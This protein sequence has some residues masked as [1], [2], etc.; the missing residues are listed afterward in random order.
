V[1]DRLA[2]NVVP[3]VENRTVVIAGSKSEYRSAPVTVYPCG[4]LSKFRTRKLRVAVQVSGVGANPNDRLPG[5][6]TDRARA[7]WNA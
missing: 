2:P 5:Q 4:R 6:A 3:F 7:D 1:K